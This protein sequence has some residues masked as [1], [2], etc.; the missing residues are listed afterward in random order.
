[1]A[2][3]PRVTSAKSDRVT[4]V[5]ALHARQGRRKTGRFVVE[6]PQAVRS[7][8][9]AG[10]VVRDLF[11][12]DSAGVSLADVV[13]LAGASGVPVTWTSP[14]ALAAMAETRQPQGVVAVCDLLLDGDLDSVMAGDGPVVVLDGVSDPGNVGTVIR[15]ADAAGA[16]GVILTRGSVDIHNGKVVRSTV[17]SLFHLPVIPE[18]E[19][20]EVA[21]A[22]RRQGRS[23]VVLAADADEDLF[24]A[25]AAALVCPRTCW[26]V[27]SE[28]HGV[29]VEARAAAD[30]SVRIPM[31]GRAE[32]LNAAVSA[33]VV[34][35]VAE[36]AYRGR[37]RSADSGPA[38]V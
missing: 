25:A 21:A 6:G 9:N 36:H 12:D 34:L 26:I 35:Y 10:V 7:A 32:S 3:S 28:A 23:I 19:F 20:A 5:R 15:T 30:L 4:A 8:L 11:M 33:A 18:A 16:S 31:Q 37:R 29:G 22:A 14:D 2:T 13:E 1:V 17:G 38:G 24:E 27:G